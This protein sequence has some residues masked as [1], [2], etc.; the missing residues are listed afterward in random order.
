MRIRMLRGWRRVLESLPA[1]LL[2][3]GHLRKK[4]HVLSP[5]DPLYLIPILCSISQAC[6]LEP[7]SQ[8]SGQISQG[9]GRRRNCGKKAGRFLWIPPCLLASNKT[10]QQRGNPRAPLTFYQAADYQ[11]KQQRTNIRSTTCTSSHVHLLSEARYM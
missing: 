3:L 1:F 10:K 5:I 9:A 8:L 2:L 7:S 11:K 4:H 6:P